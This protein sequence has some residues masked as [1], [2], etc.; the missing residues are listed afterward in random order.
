MKKILAMLMITIIS[1]PGAHTGSEER[2]EMGVAVF[3][4]FRANLIIRL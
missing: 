3:V 4:L 2:G 1:G